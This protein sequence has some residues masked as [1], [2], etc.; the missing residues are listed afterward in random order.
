MVKNHFVLWDLERTS[1]ISKG[2]IPFHKYSPFEAKVL[3]PGYT[4]DWI[5]NLHGLYSKH[6]ATS[7]MFSVSLLSLRYFFQ[8]NSEVELP[9]IS[10]WPE[11]N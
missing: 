7:V 2:Q 1:C 10:S 9:Y 3:F 11:R 4:D 6:S 8:R 5:F